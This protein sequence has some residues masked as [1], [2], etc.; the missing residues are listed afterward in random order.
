M[1]NEVAKMK[2]ADNFNR[3]QT[4]YITTT[5]GDYTKK[6]QKNNRDKPQKKLGFFLIVG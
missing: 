1:S 5:E 4:V 3:T 2:Q 6:N